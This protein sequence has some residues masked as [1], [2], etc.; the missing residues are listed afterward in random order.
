MV[1]R[2]KRNWRSTEESNIGYAYC[3]FDREIV[4]VADETGDARYRSG[5]LLSQAEHDER[6]TAICI[7]TNMEL[8]KEVEEEVEDS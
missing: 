1:R 7:T 3:W 5:H 6:A 8:A 4:V 2:S